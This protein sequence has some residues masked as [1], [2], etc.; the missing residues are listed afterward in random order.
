MCITG[1]VLCII[2]KVCVLQVG[3]VYYRLRHVYYRKGRGLSQLLRDE[4]VPVSSSDE[5]E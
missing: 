3:C 5:S 4:E 1:R 2:R